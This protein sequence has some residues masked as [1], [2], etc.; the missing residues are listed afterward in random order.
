MELEKRNKGELL[1]LWTAKIEIRE[2][3][4]KRR[5]D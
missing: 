4:R 5:F 2:G 1:Y 3:N